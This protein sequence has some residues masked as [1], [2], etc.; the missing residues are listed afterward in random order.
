M[1][2]D[3]AKSPNLYREFMANLRPFIFR[4]NKKLSRKKSSLLLV[5]NTIRNGRKKVIP[6]FILS[7]RLK[8]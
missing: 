3:K 7:Y 5:K 8:V 2:T 4:L 6:N 1:G